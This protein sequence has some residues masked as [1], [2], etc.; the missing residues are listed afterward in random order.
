MNGWETPADRRRRRRQD[1]LRD[2]ICWQPGEPLYNLRA[3][4][5]NAVGHTIAIRA[6]D[7]PEIQCER[8]TEAMEE[9]LD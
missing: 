8:L 5:A 1:I 9:L 4:V 6:S 7:P 2:L 3:R